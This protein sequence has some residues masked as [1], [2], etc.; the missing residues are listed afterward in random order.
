MQFLVFT[1][2]AP[3]CSLGEI[4]VG[5]R[6]MGW[7]RPGRSAV[8]GLA[9]A[10]LGL[11]RADAAHR[12]L[13]EALHYAVRTDAAGAPFVDYHTIQTP[14]PA[15]GQWFRTRREELEAERINTVLSTRE[16]CADACFTAALWGRD[17][18]EPSPALGEFAAA[19]REPRFT[20][21]LGRKA[22]PLGLPLDPQVIEGDTFLDA[23]AH[24]R[25]ALDA[26]AGRE[27]PGAMEAW[28]LDQLGRGVPVR[29]EIACDADAPGA[30]ADAVIVRRRDGIESRERWQF[31][32]RLE[33]V[34]MEEGEPA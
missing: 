29:R 11:T 2:Y 30:P 10:A 9:A 28:V 15:R 14:T 5:E 18:V 20:L 16:W 27:T 34:W 32:E 22:A 21:Y 33:R 4:A 3:L 17:G 7:T 1:I 24:R 6:R 23:L 12:A 8:L 26:D 31:R 25:P 19:L 13:E